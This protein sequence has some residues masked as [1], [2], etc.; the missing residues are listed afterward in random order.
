ME[1]GRMY[2]YIY[3][4]KSR[5]HT[6]VLILDGLGY[7]DVPNMSVPSVSCVGSREVSDCL[8]LR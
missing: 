8:F 6:V 1:Y 4:G 5:S 3:N 7:S 2:D